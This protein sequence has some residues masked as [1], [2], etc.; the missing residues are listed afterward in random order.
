MAELKTVQ[1]I[2]N[3]KADKE[4]QAA[5]DQTC[6]FGNFDKRIRIPIRQE[7][8][9]NMEIRLDDLRDTIKRAIFAACRAEWRSNEAQ[10]M[11]DGT[12]K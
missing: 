9:V 10:R 2:C 6:V 5:I 11:V 1:Q 12:S 8:G 4:L 7:N 3:E